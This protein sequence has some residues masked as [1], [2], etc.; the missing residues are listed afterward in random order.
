[1]YIH[2]SSRNDIERARATPVTTAT[3]VATASSSSS[4]QPPNMENHRLANSLGCYQP[5]THK[6]TIAKLEHSIV[7]FKCA[8]H[9]SDTRQQQITPHF[10]CINLIKKGFSCVKTAITHDNPKQRKVKSGEMF[11]TKNER[12]R[13][14]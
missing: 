3:V 10:V 11:D 9:A 1:M 4:T 8:V 12:R 2:T 14:K 5:S 7:L 6:Q 13:K